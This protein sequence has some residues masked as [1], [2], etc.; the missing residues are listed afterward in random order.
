MVP[1][2]PSAEERPVGPGEHEGATVGGGVPSGHVG[3][4]H[5]K[6]LGD[7]DLDVQPVRGIAGMADGDDRGSA[8]AALPWPAQKGA[9]RS[10]GVRH[11]QG[12][13]PLSRATDALDPAQIRSATVRE[14]IPRPLKSDPPAA[15]LCGLRSESVA[16]APLYPAPP[17]SGDEPDGQ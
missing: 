13:E 12:A 15:T 5:R 3:D 6:T 16:T 7:P 9:H 11:P 2:A 4:A 8:V 17:A 1:P 10:V 14:G